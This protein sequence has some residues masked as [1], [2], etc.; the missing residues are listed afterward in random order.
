M[1]SIRSLG[2][3]RIPKNRVSRFDISAEIPIIEYMNNT[4]TITEAELDALIGIEARA[5]ANHLIADKIV[6]KTSPL[7]GTKGESYMIFHRGNEQWYFRAKG[8]KA[9]QK[10]D[11]YMLD[12]SVGE[13]DYGKVRYNGINAS[14]KGKVGTLTYTSKKWYFHYDGEKYKLINPSSVEFV[15]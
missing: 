2:I 3:K 5:T 15:D 10:V 8:D 11:W 6:E 4:I 14:I 13:G 12:S 1:V 7:Y 9:F